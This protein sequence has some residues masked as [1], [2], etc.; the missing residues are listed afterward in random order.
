MSAV[1][2]TRDVLLQAASTRLGSDLQPVSVVSALPAVSGYT[3]PKIVLLTSDNKLY[4]YT[5]TAWIATTPTTDLTGQ[6]TDAQ[7]A[8]VGAAKVTGQLTDAQIAAVAAAKVTGELVA[9]QLAAS[10]VTAPKLAAGAVSTLDKFA[11]GFEPI[12][13]VGALPNPV[14]Y[15]GAR[16]VFLTTDNKLY[17]YSGTAWTVAV[18]AADLTGQITETQ[19]TDSAISTPK[20][21]A[22]SVVTAKLAAGAVTANEI[23][24]DAVTA[25]KILAGS[26]TTAKIA[27]GAVTATEIAADAITAAKI[28]AGSVTT[29]KLAAG[30]VTATEIAAGSITT[31]KIA[32]GAVTATE[33]SAGS[34][35]TTKIAAGAVTANEIATGSITTDKLTVASLGSVLVGNGGFEDPAGWT[36]GTNALRSTAANRSGVYGM[37]L[38][39]LPVPGLTSPSFPVGPGEVVSF[40][41]WARANAA[42][43]GLYLR[44]S[45]RDNLG[46]ELS[47]TDVASNL[48]VAAAFTLY[49]ANATSPANTVAAVVQVLNT[50]GTVDIDDIDVRKV[51][52]AAQIA[53][54]AITANKIAAGAI[55][56]AQIAAAT[57]TTDRLVANTATVA[58]MDSSY[59]AG[60]PIATTDSGLT[61]SSNPVGLSNTG[62]RVQWVGAAS[63]KIACAG[64]LADTPEFF[65]FTLKYFIDNADMDSGASYEEVLVRNVRLH[66]TVFLAHVL[67]P[68]FRMQTPTAGPHTYQVRV[69]VGFLNSAGQL[70]AF[71]AANGTLMS[72]IRFLVEENKV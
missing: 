71:T 35:T 4:R 51:I 60:T 47:T 18:P 31:A 6:V 55:T 48:N 20:L 24:A 68:I 8:A 3:G 30:A 27:A 57:I 54:G 59:S 62:S 23:A 38:M 65:V 26:I 61:V 7:I 49:G 22:G 10:S 36:L 66:T 40:T 63:F 45:W 44:F 70:V 56:A 41:A 21:A 12:S 16:T 15:A 32:A 11:G 58:A 28:L 39:A 5:G 2:N 37:R 17:R 9:S 50:A 67:L 46:A 34:I 42:P 43:T 64:V 19:I 52:V 33:I 13:I 69:E 14:G 1:V 53:D 25:T 72:K 29:A